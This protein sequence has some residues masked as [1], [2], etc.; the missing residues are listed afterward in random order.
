MLPYLFLS[1]SISISLVSAYFSITGLAEVFSASFVTILIMATVLELGKLGSF[2]FLHYYWKLANI[3]M[4]VYLIM[5]VLILMTINT[6]GIYGG[7]SKSSVE[8]I[9]TTS[10]QSSQIELVISKIT[11]EQGVII[12]LNNQI[13]QI[14]DNIAALTKTGRASTSLQAITQQK[15]TRDNLT[16][17][18]ASEQKTLEGL[19][20][21]KIS[22]DS[23]NKTAQ[24]TFGPIKYITALF[25]NDPTQGQLEAAVR[26]LI[27]ML[28]SV[29]DPLAA[30]LLLASLFAFSH[31]NNL[32]RDSKPDTLKIDDSIIG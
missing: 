29:F 11:Y 5:A 23:S 31:R 8:Q 15:K 26:I 4:K 18:I 27:L 19:Q 17:K 30:M 14:D 16:G 2:V 28:V 9:V 10:N 21:D 24:V 6:I 25:V 7:L 1:I 32:T 12:D 22:Q 3:L 20:Q 13:K